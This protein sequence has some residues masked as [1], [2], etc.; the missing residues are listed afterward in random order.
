M[1]IWAVSAISLI[2]FSETH[3]PDRLP[4]LGVLRPQQR[5]RPLLQSDKAAAN[6]GVRL[7]LKQSFFC[8]LPFR[9]QT[10]KN[11]QTIIVVRDQL[12]R[13]FEHEERKKKTLGRQSQIL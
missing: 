13:L 11:I 5:G 2:L 3:L 12:F 10:K 1:G 4:E 9:K 7:H 6:A 8:S